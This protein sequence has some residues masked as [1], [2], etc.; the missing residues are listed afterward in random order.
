MTC[1]G[2]LQRLKQETRER[3]RAVEQHLN[4][5]RRLKTNHDYL[6]LL[7]RLYGFYMPMELRLNDVQGLGDL[8]L[9]LDSRRKTPLL[10]S[11][12]LSLGVGPRAIAEIALCADL[13]EIADVSQAL[14]CL[15]VLEGA[16]LGGEVIGRDLER[17][18]GI[19]L[20]GGGRF[21]SSDGANIAEKWKAFGEAITAHAGDAPSQNAIVASGCATFDAFGRWF[22]RE[23]A[24]REL[25]YSA[26]A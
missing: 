22:Q 20:D 4:L 1:L 10:V 24:P 3:H 21:F 6:S 5:P 23:T 2:V 17:R 9:D 13:P 12:L 26:H 18:L 15:Y 16:T 8:G 11:D 7:A 19:Q 25:G 14:G